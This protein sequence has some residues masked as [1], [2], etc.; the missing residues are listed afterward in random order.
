MGARIYIL[1]L[2]IL[3]FCQDASLSAQDSLEL[4]K[5]L[6]RAVQEKIINQINPLPDNYG[7]ETYFNVKS[8]APLLLGGFVENA[9]Q[10]KIISVQQRTDNV[11][12]T[13]EK[14]CLTENQ[15]HI[16]E[17]NF[18]DSNKLILKREYYPQ[19][20][21]VGSAP[22]NDGKI[23]YEYKNGKLVKI[24][25]FYG[26]QELLSYERNRINVMM[27]QFDKE[28]SYT[29]IKDTNIVKSFQ[30]DNNGKQ[31]LIAEYKYDN[32]GRLV[33]GYHNSSG[34]KT[35]SMHEYLDS[36][37]L[38]KLIATIYKIMD[39]TAISEVVN[40]SYEYNAYGL[41]RSQTLLVS[42]IHPERQFMYKNGE[43]LKKT[44]YS[45]HFYNDEKGRLA[46]HVIKLIEGKPQKFGDSEVYVF[47][48]KY[49]WIFK[50]FGSMNQQYPA[51]IKARLITYY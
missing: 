26:G 9:S 10:V 27:K 30:V 12:L 18:N 42:N 41:I 32:L 1:M 24:E 36:G 2:Q 47:D 37:R 51:N 33:Q 29:H 15:E 50:T 4:F 8:G 28:Y 31:F 25:T 19:L 34:M 22:L 44:N 17:F 38:S 11:P 35:E 46:V 43:E 21:T 13:F 14:A 20:L 40:H 23:I 7:R 3:L 49:N 6:P 48:E 45:Y 16:A 39:T 5:A